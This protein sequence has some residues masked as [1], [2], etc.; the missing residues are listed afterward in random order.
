MEREEIIRRCQLMPKEGGYNRSELLPIC[1]QLGI[2]VKQKLPELRK[3]V[4]SR[5]GSGSSVEKKVRTPEDISDFSVEQ[6]KERTKDKV[7]LSIA[8]CFCP[9]HAGHY[10]LVDT[11]IS[12]I[13]PDIVIINSVNRNENPRHGTPLSHT[14]KTWKNW[15][16]ILSKK[17][18]VDLYIPNDYINDLV[19]GGGAEYIKAYVQTDV[20]E[21]K[22]M[23]REYRRNPLQQSSLE[24]KSL[25]FLYKVPRDFKGYYI[26]H[27]Q[28]EGDLSATA[29][30]KCLKDLQ[31]DCLMYV[32]NDV[33]DKK[34][35]IDDIRKNYYDELH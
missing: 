33:K 35:Y 17:H 15:G 13:K 21:G 10:N 34:A 12:K 18:N 28:R 11:A 1:K 9:P 8:G 6:L 19:W 32:P 27:I 30:V 25:S 23:P 4:I 26:Y 5:L 24:N 14:L 20:W 31:S 7:I 16:N 2:D 22:E 3:T 29:F